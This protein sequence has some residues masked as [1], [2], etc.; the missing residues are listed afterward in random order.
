MAAQAHST[1]LPRN[2]MSLIKWQ[3]DPIIIHHHNQ[4]IPSSGP[5]MMDL[6]DSISTTSSSSPPPSQTKTGAKRGRPR[7]TED[8][9]LAK[10]VTLLTYGKSINW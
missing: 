6:S 5:K 3:D 4:Y 8:A 1:V 7:L 10:L 9:E 2:I